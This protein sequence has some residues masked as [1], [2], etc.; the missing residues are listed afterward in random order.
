M[1]TKQFIRTTAVA[2]VVTLLTTQAYAGNVTIGKF[3]YSLDKRSKEATIIGTD[4]KQQI[5]G[6]LV[7]PSTISDKK[8]QYSVT[9]IGAQAFKGLHNIVA[10]ELPS[11]LKSIGSEAF[12]NCTGITELSLPNYGYSIGDRAFL[13]CTGLRSLLVPNGIK[14]ISWSAFSGC[15]GVMSVDCDRNL[16]GGW[17]AELPN[18]Q[19]LSIGKNVKEVSNGVIQKCKKLTDLFVD[20]K[21]VSMENDA[22][23]NPAWFS[24]INVK[25]VTLGEH[26]KVI[27]KR[28]FKGAKLEYIDMSK[29]D[30]EII[31]EEAF[32]M[33]SKLKTVILPR[34]I[35]RIM[36]GAF[37][38]CESLVSIELPSGLKGIWQCA[39][40]DCTSLNTIKFPDS[41]IGIGIEA[42]YGCKSL[43][44]VSTPETVI[45]NIK[46]KS[47]FS[48]CEKLKSITVRNSN[49]TE[50][51]S[52]EWYW[53]M[54]TDPDLQKRS[55]TVS[56]NSQSSG[57]DPN[58]LDIPS[59]ELGNWEDHSGYRDCSVYL[60]NTLY[61]RLE[62]HPDFRDYPYVAVTSRKTVGFYKTKF[63]A[64]AAIYFYSNYELTRT[65][66]KR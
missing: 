9:T 13:N 2:I 23:N 55:R 25:R 24:F 61:G 39:F 16:T 45:P 10:L 26:V 22:W 42:F 34:K 60:N 44:S 54:S 14:S 59:Y 47:V 63:D 66:G 28:A 57:V 6:K 32:Y 21:V 27:H 40:K 11:T 19:K 12:A 1:S 51:Q 15:T 20:C 4:T 65:K 62:Y 17:L 41:M 33:C 7:I 56:S 8:G 5:T 50:K 43:I 49:G 29:S 30:I 46:G 53:F 31:E 48:Q 37:A 58:S 38:N 52:N 35:Q 3:I 18:L 36:N 64:I